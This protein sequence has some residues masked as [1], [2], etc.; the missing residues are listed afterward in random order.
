MERVEVAAK[1]VSIAVVGSGYVGLVAAVC[2]AEIGHSVVCVDNDEQKVALLREGGVP[3][4]EDFL[5]ELL[6]RHRNQR[7]QFTTDLTEATR[8]AQAIFI[9][10]GTPQ[11]D[12]GN[13]D[14]SYVDAV[15]TQ[16]A[17][18]IGTYKVIVEKSTVPVYTNEWIR[19]VVERN[20]TSSTNF[21][22]A[23]NPEFLREGTAVSDFLHPDR[24]V[25]GADSD[26]AAEILKSIYAPLTSGDYYKSDGAIIGRCT[27]SDPPPLLQTS[28]KA[29]ELIKHASNAFLAMKI[30]F[31]NAVANVCEAVDAN[32]EE[33]ARGMGLDKRIGSQFLRAGIGYGGSCFP[34]DV[35][36]FRYVAEQL[37][38]DFGILSEVEK[39]NEQQKRRFFNKVRSALWTF[40]GKR[41]AV[42]GL[43]FKG[44]TDDVRES[45]AF[46]IIRML[47]AEGCTIVA[48]DP[49]ATERAKAELPAGPAMQYA[50]DIYAAVKDAD[51][52]LILSDWP[53]FGEL[54]LEKLQAALRYPIVID[55]RN[56]YD[57]QEMLERG[58]TYLS[59]GRPAMYPARERAGARRVP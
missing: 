8:N 55:G 28:T 58:F 10:V 18:C 40:R 5:P 12:S 19:R 13:A 22:V 36:A 48:Y 14:L 31:I 4:H 44:G 2:F 33:V 20:G 32:V 52:V 9:A 49:A 24:I 38:V 30:S 41:L 45:P 27:I 54:N 43:A 3:I 21:D 53:Q 7:L 26:Q 46:E 34:K 17:R 57:P 23:S 42:L 50:D 47:L 35:A 51:A 16:I 25:I 6:A 56:L 15:A 39:I 29:A 59:V 37:S 11:S 1:P